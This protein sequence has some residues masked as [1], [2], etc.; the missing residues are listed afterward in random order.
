MSAGPYEHEVEARRE[1]MPTAVG[2]ESVAVTRNWLRL[3]ALLEACERSG[4]ELG[5]FDRR[6]LSWLA[7]YEAETV[8]VVVGLVERA[9]EAGMAAGLEAAR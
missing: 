3:T 8:Q 7:G 9:Y 4:V 5:A 6:I 2:A 1:P